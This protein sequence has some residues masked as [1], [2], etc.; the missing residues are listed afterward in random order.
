[1]HHANPE[2]EPAQHNQPNKSV[3]DATVLA[4]TVT[5][6]PNTDL[7]L[8]KCK[9][10]YRLSED[11]EAGP[12]VEEEVGTDRLRL[13]EP[14]GMYV[15]VWMPAGG[16]PLFVSS[17]TVV[18]LLYI[19]PTCTQRR[20][21]RRWTSRR[22]WAGGR[23]WRCASWMRRCVSLLNFRVYLLALSVDQPRSHHQRTHYDIK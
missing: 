10:A 15:R 16:R 20:S 7:V 3:A 14:K 9:V 4:V 2:P 21:P 5:A 19:H 22:A 1:M 6:V 11:P 8:R 23:P 18:C 13:V 12:V 17:D